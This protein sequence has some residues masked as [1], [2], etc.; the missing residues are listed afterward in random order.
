M[1]PI[2]RWQYEKLEDSLGLLEDHIADPECP[3]H[4]E[5]EN[6]ARK[7][8]KRAEAYAQET[9]I[10]LA[11]DPK[12]LAEEIQKLEDLANEAREWRRAEENL[13]CGK[14]VKPDDLVSAAWASGWRKY[15]ET[16]LVGT[17]KVTA[18]KATLGETTVRISGKCSP[19]N[20]KGCQFRVTATDK[21]EGTTVSIQ[22]LTKLIQDVSRKASQ[23][24]KQI[25]SRTF[26]NGTT[27]ITRYE[28]EYRI[29][30][31]LKLSVS[32]DPE[33]FVPSP[34]YPQE[35]QPRL[36]ERAATRLQVERMAANLDPM[37]LLTEY[38]AIDR[39]APIVGPDMVVE[40]G[41]G[42]TMAL[43]LAYKRHP[44]V[45]TKYLE[46]LIEKA[47]DFGLEVGTGESGNKAP[48][49]VRVRITEVDRKQF[50]QEANSSTTIE[51]SAVEKA[52]TDA[53]KISVEMLISLEVLE[54]ENIEDALRAA[55]N[56]GFVKS[57]LSRLPE[58]EQARLVDAKGQLN[59][60]GIRR[61]TMAIFVATFKGD[62][63]LR[64]AE[65]FFESTDVAV[66]TVFGGITRSLGILARAESLAAAGERMPDYAIGE[67]LA[68]AVA[69]FA[70]IKKT[71]GLTVDTY[72]HQSQMF[73]RELDAFQEY[74]LT[75]LDINSRSARKIADILREYARLVIESPSP[76]Q[77]GLLPEVRPLK[78]DLFKTAVRGA[79]LS[80][81]AAAVLHSPHWLETK[82]DL[83]NLDD[84]QV[85]AIMNWRP[86]RDFLA[87][88]AGVGTVKICESGMGV[89][90]YQV[91]IGGLSAENLN[92]AA[93]RARSV[94]TAKRVYTPN[95][96]A[97]YEIS[98]P[99]TPSE[100]TWLPQET[101]K[102][103]KQ[104]A[105][106]A[107][108]FNGESTVYPVNIPR[109][110][111]L[112]SSL[113]GIVPDEFE[114]FK[115]QINLVR[116]PAWNVKDAPKI[117]RPEDVQP[118]AYLMRRA[119][120]EWLLVVCTNTGG[121]LVGLFEQS[122][123]THDYALV[124][125]HELA[126]VALLTG[127]SNLLLAHNHPSGNNEPS[128]ADRTTFESVKNTL[129]PLQINVL[130]LLVIGQ[131]ADYSIA[132]NRGMPVPADQLGPPV[133][134]TP[135]IQKEPVGTRQQGRLFAELGKEDKPKLIEITE[136]RV[137]KHYRLKTDFHKTS[138]RVK[139]LGD[140]LIYLGCPIDAEWTGKLCSD[141][142]VLQKT[143][144]NRTPAQ[145]KKV[146]A[147]EKAGVEVI[148]RSQ[149]KTMPFTDSEIINAIAAAPVVG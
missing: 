121:Q 128:Q 95:P 28:F 30:D 51:S 87:W 133:K 5:G 2:I 35:L 34:D 132:G 59:Q 9:M 36:R 41:N 78:I 97:V 23:A 98:I 10:I 32:H 105:E 137:V 103:K 3:C 136:T 20:G 123:G 7:H 71:P 112:Q 69:V 114:K 54:N 141:N 126:R 12:S 61:L 25:S 99:Q 76:A 37:S 135:V 44:D 146:A 88:G 24:K 64:L 104:P 94:P 85:D 124:D 1:K 116:S 139:K 33:T 134:V 58:N 6:C 22:D 31:A 109:P 142:Q 65:R 70:A 118:F 145:M 92:Q 148:D 120:R 45:W 13:L 53:G 47:P 43:I 83:C 49:L 75:V 140:T 57:F 15:F 18:G 111:I 67:D 102:E 40:S 48:V 38:H 129:Q 42:R 63:G 81:I 144:V 77:G 4:S 107:A 106:Q 39:G 110:E 115:V 27:N 29:V 56:S 101:K 131:S 122:I 117:T 68:K 89:G 127:A 93:I 72:L 17:C 16:M 149:D 50:V 74:I 82:V 108:L 96:E 119:D 60:D 100:L 26:A 79:E 46:G 80:D 147:W 8:L 113:H 66:R 90:S 19:V 125:A 91:H 21:I 86:L 55:R 11:R 143:V 84:K 138:F 14:P 73:E 130:D 62:V 52:R